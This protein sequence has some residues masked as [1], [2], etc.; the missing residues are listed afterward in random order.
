MFP[1]VVDER[2]A[3]C[4]C[5]GVNM[6]GASIA[7]A[8]HSYNA[9]C[10]QKMAA[11]ACWNRG[12]FRWDRLTGAGAGTLYVIGNPKPR[13]TLLMMSSSSSCEMMGIL[14]WW[15]LLAGSS[16][17][18]VAGCTVREAGAGFCGVTGRAGMRSLRGLRG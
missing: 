8:I 7:C 15:S 9:A 2:T 14:V 18:M 10:A 16:S 4:N 13:G 5:C 1:S 6:V 3:G 12:R 11:L 17:K